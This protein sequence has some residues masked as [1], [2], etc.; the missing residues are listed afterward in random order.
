MHW[1]NG[2]FCKLHLCLF[3]FQVCNTSEICKSPV[4]KKLVTLKYFI[5][6]KRKL[7][8][9][10]IRHLSVD[11]VFFYHLS[12]FLLF[13]KEFFLENLK[14]ILENLKCILSVKKL[15]KIKKISDNT[16]V[17]FY[18]NNSHT[19]IIKSNTND[20]CQRGLLM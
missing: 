14:C 1:D 8:T 16:A 7:Y 6:F 10:N 12:Y 19:S 5:K 11:V 13:V 3:L 15:N 9:R 20:R 18:I 17:L 2:A 4:R